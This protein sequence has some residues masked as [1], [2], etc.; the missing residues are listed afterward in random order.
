MRLQLNIRKT[1]QFYVKRFIENSFNFSFVFN[2]LKKGL[3][4]I[5]ITKVGTDSLITDG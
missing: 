1:I 2:V 4:Q 5:A 3:L